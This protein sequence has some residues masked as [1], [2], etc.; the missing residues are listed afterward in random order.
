MR[1]TCQACGGNK[2]Y[3]FYQA[4]H[5]PVHSCLMVGSRAEAM[6]FPR[7]DLELVFCQDCGFIGNALY[8]PR[9]QAYSPAYEE[10]QIFSPRFRHFLSELC[11][12]QIQRYDLAGKSVLEIGCGK[13]E[14]LAILCERGACSGIGIDPSY[15]PE[16]LMSTAAERIQFIQDF[17]GPA[18]AHLRADYVCCRH[19]LEHIG[20]VG[21]F[22]ALV[23]QAIDQQSDAVV[24]FEL[25]DMQRVLVESAFWD[26]YY[27]HC[28]YFT[29]GSLTRLF[30][31]TGFVPHR[32]WKAYDDQYVMIEARPGSEPQLTQLPG[33]DDLER[34]FAQVRHFERVIASRIQAL[35]AQL[36]DWRATGEKVVLWGSGSKAVSYLTV[37]GVTNE[38]AAVVDINPHKHGKFLAGSGHEIVSPEAL[39]GISPDH[40]VVMNSIYENEIRASLAQMGLQPNMTALT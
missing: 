4:E 9:L 39:H 28:S 10:T 40:V 12:D 11:D 32:L 31:R 7:G 24:F 37:L 15:R 21:D 22:M 30:R 14:F 34:T 8:D 3:R 35:R 13:G 17:Y 5:I 19:T 6:S 2:G 27:E 29:G 36:A 26:I 18:Y 16:R 25:P 33:E 23:R 20:A 38:V 1:F